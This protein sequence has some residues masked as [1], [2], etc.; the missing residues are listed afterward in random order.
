ML[1]GLLGKKLGMTQIFSKEGELVPVTIVQVGPCQVLELI[2]EPKRKVKL[3]FSP[4]KEH[5]STKPVLG[6]FKKIGVAP[7]RYIREIEASDEEKY[8][9]GQEIRADFFKAGD[10]IDITG[11]SIGKGFQ[12]GM[13]RW[14]WSGGPG[15]HG[16][17][18]HR[19]V[20]SIGASAD[21]SRTFRGFNMP[22]QMGNKRAT[23]QGLRV[24][25]VDIENNFILVKGGVPGHKN[26]FLTIKR[27]KK[28]AFRSLD[29]VQEVVVRKINPMKQSKAKAG[30]KKKGK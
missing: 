17:M 24:M 18:H 4:I 28:K 30:K 13:K 2:E 6:Y 26:A 21:P 16:S 20:G 12:G 15:G 5:R 10:F 9:V 14:H 25:D 1:R 8:E 3:G 7:M 29:E 11:T 19:R 23:I 27:S 22:G